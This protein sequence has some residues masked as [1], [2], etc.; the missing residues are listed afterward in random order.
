MIKYITF[1]F[2][3]ELIFF[4]LFLLYITLKTVNSKVQKSVPT[5]EENSVIKLTASLKTMNECFIFVE[6]L[7]PEQDINEVNFALSIVL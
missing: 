3:Q 5:F 7:R 1:K 2:I 4:L 6:H